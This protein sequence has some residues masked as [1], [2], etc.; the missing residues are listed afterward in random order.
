V[1]KVVKYA[2]FEE[3]LYNQKLATV[4]HNHIVQFLK[5]HT[6][7]QEGAVCLVF[8]AI[9]SAPQI[10]INDDELRMWVSQ[11]YEVSALHT[12]H[13]THTCHP[14]SHL[15]LSFTLTHLLACPFAMYDMTLTYS[16]SLLTTICTSCMPSRQ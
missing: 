5:H 15:S 4:S 2:A 6:N 3:I 13:A 16:L 1:L 10:P 14:L 8:E 9:D 12:L 11:L 7:M